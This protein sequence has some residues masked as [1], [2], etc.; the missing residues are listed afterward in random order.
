MKLLRIVFL[1][2]I[3]CTAMLASANPIILEKFKETYGKP[4]ADCLVCHTQPPKRNEYGKAVEAA[5]IQSGTTEITAKVFQ[6]IEKSDADSDGVSNSDEIKADTMPG[7]AKSKPA[8]TANGVGNKVE[9]TELIPKHSLHPAIIHFPIAL[10]AVAALL[11]ILSVRKSDEIYHKASVI[12][13]AIALICSIGAIISG[14]AAWLRLGYVLE[15]NLLIHLILAS[16]SILIGLAAYLQREKPA[17]LWLIGASGALVLIAG[18]FGG[19]MV[20]G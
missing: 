7:D 9:S 20:Y 4:K 15:G 16:L 3:T 19:T 18:H 5:L 14:I 6:A 17:Y 10:L 13:L 11:Q 8:Q 1:G 2:T 12:N